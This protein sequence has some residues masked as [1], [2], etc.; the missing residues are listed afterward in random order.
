MWRK[1]EEE[2]ERERLARERLMNEVQMFLN[3]VHTLSKLFIWLSTVTSLQKY[4]CRF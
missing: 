4:I 1:R 2:W 3:V